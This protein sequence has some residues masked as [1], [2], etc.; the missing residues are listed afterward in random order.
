MYPYRILTILYPRE[1]PL[2]LVFN[3]SQKKKH[4]RHL[5]QPHRR[6]R[7]SGPGGSGARGPGV[8]SLGV[9]QAIPGGFK[10]LPLPRFSLSSPSPLLASTSRLV[11]ASFPPIRSLG[12]R[13]IPQ[14]RKHRASRQRERDGEEVGSR[15]W[16][17]C[18]RR[19]RRGRV[20]GRCW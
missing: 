1:I 2:C 9:R 17:R 13:L 8:T 19:R 4:H 20:A 5:H 12:R 16:R 11:D 15:G 7:G 3:P 10:F 6:T 18:L 14:I